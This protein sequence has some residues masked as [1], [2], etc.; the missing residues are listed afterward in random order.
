[1]EI[2]LYTNMRDNLIYNFKNFLK[3]YPLLFEVARWFAGGSRVG[4]GPKEAIKGVE[5]KILNLG[6]GSQRIRKDVINL[7]IYPY[8]NVDIVGDIYN[9]P[10][11]DNEVDAIICDQVLEHLKDT[12]RAIK[13][14]N[15][16]LKPAGLIYVA[17]PFVAGYH[18]SPDDYYRFSENGLKAVMEQH[19]FQVIKSG[20]RQ[21]PTSA[22]L[23]IF[24]RWLA[25]ILS[26]GSGGLYQLW[27]MMFMALTFP[28][29]FLDYL[30]C[31]FKPAE[32]IAFGFY[33]LG[34][35]Q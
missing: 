9:L 20:I 5:G 24:N 19:G 32:N 31:K 11:S 23:S 26:F 21:G 6:S 3:K 35:K 15:R 28:S 4:L 2:F 27:L 25:L 22:L 17:V 7:D 13:E 30:I 18:S 10:F 8:H 34:K 29:K 33:Y 14:M 1:M 12:A 16:V